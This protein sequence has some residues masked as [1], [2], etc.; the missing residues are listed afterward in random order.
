MRAIVVAILLVLVGVAAG[1]VR[2]EAVSACIGRILAFED[3]IH[4]SDDAI[5]GGRITRAEISG[6]F[7]YDVTMD[8]DLVVRGP[9]TPRLRRVQAGDICDG[10]RVGEWGYIV[11]DV[12]DPNWPGSGPDDLFFPIGRYVARNALIAAGLPNTSTLPVDTHEPRS[13]HPLS[14]LTIWFVT[15]FVL[16]LRALA[17][18]REEAIR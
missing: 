15:A 5:Y 3:A 14:L 12:H 1:T 8:I 10:I 16:A 7:F 17:R 4:L 2:P 18:R 11:R 13:S 6:T 9:V